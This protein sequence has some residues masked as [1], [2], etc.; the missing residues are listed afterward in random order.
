[1]FASVYMSKIIFK[2]Y[3]TNGTIMSSWFYFTHFS[4]FLLSWNPPLWCLVR[5]RIFLFSSDLFRGMVNAGC[6]VI[7]KC[8][9]QTVVPSDILM[10]HSRKPFGRETIEVVLGNHCTGHIAGF[11]LRSHILHIR[12]WQFGQQ[13]IVD[14][15]EVTTASEWN[16]GEL[17]VLL[18]DL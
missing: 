2:I 10:L 7:H 4:N 5:L 14:F 8:L 12:F 16:Q 11:F 3:S 18:F 13:I 6:D 9:W 17:V 15:L 1:M